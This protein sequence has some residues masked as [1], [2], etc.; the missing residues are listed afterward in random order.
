MNVFQRQIAF[1]C[2]L[3]V[4]AANLGRVAGAAGPAAKKEEE[5]MLAVLLEPRYDVPPDARDPFR[6]SAFLIGIA[7]ADDAAGTG[8]SGTAN[9]AVK[10]ALPVPP[11]TAPTAEEVCRAV[12]VQAVFGGSSGESSAIL[13]GQL[14]KAGDRLRVMVRGQAFDVTVKR[15]DLSAS[16]VTV[17]YKESE[18]VVSLQAGKKKGP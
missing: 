10:A 15:V 8:K 16:A 18:R 13:N 6:P 2:L 7:P 11:T 12:T 1:P 14:A 4:L 17:A 5:K 3:V 9:T